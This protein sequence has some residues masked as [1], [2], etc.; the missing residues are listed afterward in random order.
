MRTLGESKVL[1]FVSGINQGNEGGESKIFLYYRR[2]LG[3]SP[4][5]FREGGGVI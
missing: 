3:A 1:S 5:S 4:Q 2:S